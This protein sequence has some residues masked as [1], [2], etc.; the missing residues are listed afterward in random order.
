MPHLGGVVPRG[1]LGGDLL[2]G[3]RTTGARPTPSTAT[4]GS[5]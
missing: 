3:P 5:G 1:I 4:H 2:P